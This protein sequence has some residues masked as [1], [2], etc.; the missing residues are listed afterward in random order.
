MGASS[1]EDL[2]KPINK[3]RLKIAVLKWYPG[4]P[5]ANE[6]TSSSHTGPCHWWK[7]FSE[8]STLPGNT[9]PYCKRL[10]DARFI[11]FWLVLVS[12]T[13]SSKAGQAY[14]IPNEANQSVSDYDS[15]YAGVWPTSVLVVGLI[16]EV[17]I[18]GS[19]FHRMLLHIPH[20]P[21]D[22]GVLPT[23]QLVV[24]VV[25]QGA[26]HVTSS[27][28]PWVDVGHSICG[29]SKGNRAMHF[30]SQGRYDECF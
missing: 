10:M 12:C 16:S 20:R 2:K 15:M 6:L 9:T 3:T 17:D 13:F 4:L 8:H 30:M 23:T 7:H 22:H 19:R 21:G 5:G 29:L 11:D 1:L 25:D 26:V 18:G 24:R 27:W 28:V 14:R